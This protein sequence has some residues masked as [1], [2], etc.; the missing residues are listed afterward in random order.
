M[1][2]RDVLP[3]V[4]I[5]SHY[6]ISIFN[7]DSVA[8]TFHGEVSIDLNVIETTDK[9]YLNYRDLNI[10]HAHLKVDGVDLPVKSIDHVK[11]KETVIINLESPVDPT[12]ATITLKYTAIIQTNM[13]GFYKSKYKDVNGNDAIMLSTQFEATDARRAFPSFDEPNLK[14]TFDVKLTIQDDWVGL[15]NM[16]V[17]D[18]ISNSNGTKT[19][20]FDTTPTMST[21]LIAWA[22]GDLEYIETFT[23]K[24]THNGSKIPVR[25]YTT[26]GLIAQGQLAL[27]NTSKI[28]DYFSE[29]FDID[30]AL[31]KVDLL[32]VHEFSHGA[33][34]NWGLITYRTT[35]LLYD[36]TTSDAK[37]KNRVVYVVAHELAHQ[38][39]GNLV[40][41]D[42]W[43][44]L[45]LN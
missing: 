44:E 4:A 45:W 34:E 13:A 33:M 35:A 41:M 38:W 9:I 40:T 1:S 10:T 28:V 20:I 37:Y 29:I 22:A 18:T 25:V 39:F 43:N 17:I 2:E 12:N 30:Y 3:K 8:E 31:P 42:W 14:A 32:A 7:V 27:E 6:Q 23:E 24:T 26:K 16:P 5:P 36:E 21:Y 19:L 15:G 11:E